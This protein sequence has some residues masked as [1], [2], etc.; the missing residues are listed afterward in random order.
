MGLFQKFKEFI[1]P[2]PEIDFQLALREESF[3]RNFEKAAWLYQ[4]AV[5]QGHYKAMY[6]LAELYLR[7]RG[8]KQDVNKALKLLADSSNAGYDKATD[9]LSKIETG[10]YQISEE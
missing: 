2:D 1:K 8:V 10:E 4:K 7:G 5:D 9:L 6:F 3:S